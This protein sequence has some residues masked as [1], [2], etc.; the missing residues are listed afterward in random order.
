MGHRAY[1]TPPTRNVT[2]KARVPRPYPP[3]RPRRAAHLPIGIE[4]SRSISCQNSSA[5]KIRPTALPPTPA[6]DASRLG[7]FAAAFQGPVQPETANDRA[8]LVAVAHPSQTARDVFS[9]DHPYAGGENPT[10]AVRDDGRHRS[11]L[12]HLGSAAVVCGDRRGLRQPH[13]FK[14]GGFASDRSRVESNLQRV[15]PTGNWRERCYFFHEFKKIHRIA[16]RL[17]WGVRFS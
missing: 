3:S 1:S 7:Q 5:T 8:Q 9:P 4:S 13:R 2:L 11:E 12:V 15:D 14:G 16:L 6:T 10:T 17:I